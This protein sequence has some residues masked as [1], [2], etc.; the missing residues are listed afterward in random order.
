M[1]TQDFFKLRTTFNFFKP[2]TFHFIQ[3]VCSMYQYEIKE[4]FYFKFEKLLG[5]QNKILL[6]NRLSEKL[7]GKYNA[8]LMLLMSLEITFS[9]QTSGLTRKINFLGD[10]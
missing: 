4:V 6:S 8:P 3:G 10:V 1:F 2:S 9:Q 7:I 5:V